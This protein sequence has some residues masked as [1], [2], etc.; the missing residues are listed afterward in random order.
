MS[1][2]ASGA[3]SR[4]SRNIPRIRLPFILS[5]NTLI[6]RLRE[7]FPKYGDVIEVRG[8]PVKMFCLRH[9][10][11]LKQIYAYEKTA[12]S[13]HPGLLPRV[14][15]VMRAGSFV[16]PGGD[17]WRRKRQMTQPLFA[18]APCMAFASATV[19]AMQPGLDRWAEM[20][21]RGHPVDIGRQLGLLTIDV[22]FKML[23]SE[24][25]GSRLEAVYEQT[26]WI[27]RSFADMSPLWLPLPKN[28]RFR[29]VARSLMGLMRELIERRLRNPGGSG[30]VL[31]Y[32]LETPDKQTGQKWGADE[33][34]DELFSIYFGASI[35]RI[36]LIWIFSLL[37]RHPHAYHRLKEEIDVVLQGRPPTVEDM[38]QLHQPE[39]VFN[40]TTRLY[41]PVWGYP[42]Y[43]VEDLDIDDFRFPAGSL[44]LPLGYFAHRHPEF[45]EN[46]DIFDPERFAP[47][48]RSKI[49]PFAHYPFGG[50]PRM[51]L[52]RNLGPMVMQL[53]LV[54]I[55]Q[56]YSLQLPLSIPE[57]PVPDFGF[58]LSPRDKVIMTIHRAESPAPCPLT[59]E[60][61]ELPHDTAVQ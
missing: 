39:M 35:M 9:P 22:I 16:H 21:A 13:K 38:A 44:L 59:P 20:A 45:W 24:D 48:R 18:R 40:E 3:G 52:G 27:L 34:Q 33:V 2:G 50:G 57:D 36:G 26:D 23:F 61:Q 47:G 49:H 58:E 1:L 41:P 15:W 28:F 14:N 12:I 6:A 37:A 60:P 11:H 32:L 55:A 10:D 8:L 31:S 54:A 51:C 43:T 25:L 7:A 56:R 46:A 42:R 53:M 30:D 5:G 17:E 19:P 4:P 29:R